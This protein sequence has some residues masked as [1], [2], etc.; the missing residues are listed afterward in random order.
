M[1]MRHRARMAT[2]NRIALLLL[3][4]S[5]SGPGFAQSSGKTVRHH[6]I[7]TQESAQSADLARAE[8]LLAKKGLPAAEALLQKVTAAEP[9]NYVAW[10]DLGFAQNGLGK[11]ADSIA[12]YKKSVEL[13]PDV[14]ESN[15]NLGLTLAK[16]GM[17]DAEKYLQAATTLKPTA[18]V[19]EGQARA[20]VSLGHVLEKTDPERA[21]EAFR[22][23]ARL[24]P[25]DPE[26]HLS[27]GQLLESQN[28]FADAEQ[29]YKQVLAIQPDSSDALAGIANV[30]MRGQRFSDAEQML[31]R[32]VELHPQDATAHLQLARVLVLAG[33]YDDGI[34]QLLATL[35]IRPND[36]EAQ[37]GLADAYLSAGKY[38]AAALQYQS[39]L[40]H[41]P[42]DAE[43]HH[44][45]GQAFL[46]SSKFPEGQ[47]ESLTAV[48]LKPDLGSATGT[49]PSRP[50]RIRITS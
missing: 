19:E 47:Q 31:Q 29:E 5:L 40:G 33:K 43:L 16:A 27:A 2:T 50:T 14:F 4:F 24:Q 44:S 49:W 32:F 23:A 3:A 41:K 20:F 48:K 25:S 1:E 46:K 10:F 9:S 42:N 18:R 35:K 30:Y 7:A 34:S 8:S 12:S 38:D 26:P 17:P 28:R 36:A 37:R 22:N 45:R 15:L 13:K 39:L 11:T 21:L 6:T